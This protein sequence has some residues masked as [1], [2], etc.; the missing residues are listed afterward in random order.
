MKITDD[1]ILF[2]LPDPILRRCDGPIWCAMREAG[3]D[4]SPWTLINL[5]D[6]WGM[7]VGELIAQIR[8]S[9]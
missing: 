6:C 3:Y 9:A 1:T 5:W 2:D 7:T 4:G 8:A